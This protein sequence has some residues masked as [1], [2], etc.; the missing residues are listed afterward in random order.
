M[1]HAFYVYLSCFMERVWEGGVGASRTPQ[2]RSQESTRTLS[3]HRDRALA[4]PGGLALLRTRTVQTCARKGEGDGAS[5]AVGA[6][7]V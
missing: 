7:H 1:V 4:A 2:L 5:L 3:R 6:A